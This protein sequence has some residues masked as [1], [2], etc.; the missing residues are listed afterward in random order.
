MNEKR[1][2]ADNLLLTH[3]VSDLVTDRVYNMIIIQSSDK[4]APSLCLLWAGTIPVSA[5]YANQTTT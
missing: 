2:V 5:P 1:P 3:M 4:R